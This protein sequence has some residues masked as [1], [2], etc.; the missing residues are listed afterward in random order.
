[1]GQKVRLPQDLFQLLFRLLQ[2]Q[3]EFRRRDAQ[4]PRT[5]G[6]D[7]DHGVPGHDRDPVVFPD[8]RGEA[9]DIGIRA[10]PLRGK[11]HTDVGMQRA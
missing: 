1:M 3:H 9:F 10:F 11:G 7:A 8:L 5:H 2:F 4:N 6:R